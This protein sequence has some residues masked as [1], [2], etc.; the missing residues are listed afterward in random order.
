LTPKELYCTI[1]FIL[2]WQFLIICFGQLTYF[3]NLIEEILPIS[4]P[5]IFFSFQMCYV[6]LQ[7]CLLINH[8]SQNHIIW[9]KESFEL[10]ILYKLVSILTKLQVIQVFHLSKNPTIGTPLAKHLILILQ[11]MHIIVLV[12]FVIVPHDLLIG[13]I[14]YLNVKQVINES[15]FMCLNE[16]LKQ[17]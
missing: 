5:M 13:L 11:P 3:Y 10:D 9:W 4:F 15:L 17:I 16:S 2:T 1:P 14:H 12:S 8:Y 7:L 6:H